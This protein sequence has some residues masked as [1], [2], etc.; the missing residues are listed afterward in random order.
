MWGF[1]MSNNKYE[2]VYEIINIDGEEVEID[3]KCVDMVLFFNQIGMKTKF[4]CEGHDK[5]IYYICFDV[6]DDQMYKFAKKTSEWTNVIIIP[7]SLE[8]TKWITKRIRVGL[9]GRIYKM[10]WYTSQGKLKEFWTYQA[11]GVTLEDAQRQARVDLVAL[12]A[13][14]FGECLEEIQ[15]IQQENADNK[16]KL[17]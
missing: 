16:L 5:S 15:L 17:Y 7:T 2:Q 10:I 9:N 12:K 4:C 3:E 14:Y 6:S 8:K 1:I 13:M 11:E